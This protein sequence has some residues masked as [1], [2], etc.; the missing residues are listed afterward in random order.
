M[1]ATHFRYGGCFTISLL[2]MMT[3][4]FSTVSFAA[5]SPENLGTIKASTDS[6]ALLEP[7]ESS[8]TYLS[9]K[10]VNLAQGIDQFFGDPR[11]FQQANNSV[12]QLYLTEVFEPGGIR[13]FKF[14]GQAKVDLP[15]TQKRLSLVFESDPEKNIGGDIKKNQQVIPNARVTSDNQALALRY[16]NRDIP[17]WYFN[18]DVGMKLN[19]PVENFARSR[20]SY[21]M[22]LGDWQFRASETVFWFQTIGAGETSQIDFDKRLSE[23]LL[24]RSSSV[25]TW[26]VE[27]LNFDLRQDFSLYQTLN[28]REALLYQTSAIGVSQPQWEVSEYVALLLYRKRL[29]HKWV[30][31]EISPQLHFPIAKNYQVSPLLMVRLEILFDT[32]K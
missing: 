32:A 23:P 25:A 17:S 20:A 12:L 31:C 29:H 9:E 5:D 3:A 28:E 15:S 18:A 2:L 13:Q 1:P 22:P 14:D 16:E 7:T 4:I 30:F 21:S 26:L 27:K 6:L 11:Y 10:F 19:I 24:F 8:R